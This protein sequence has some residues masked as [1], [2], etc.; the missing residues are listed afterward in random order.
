MHI[1]F[2]IRF[3]RLFGHKNKNIY[4]KAFKGGADAQILYK[5]WWLSDTWK[6]GGG[7]LIDRKVRCTQWSANNK[8][9]RSSHTLP[10][11]QTP[12]NML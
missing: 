8:K 3:M 10:H 9:T 6:N 7:Q 5:E 12:L 4:S 1:D 2:S 11:V